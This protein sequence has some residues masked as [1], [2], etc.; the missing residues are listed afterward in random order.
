MKKQ[1]IWSRLFTIGVVCAYLGLILILVLQALT[2]GH[3]SG[4]ISTNVG[5]KIDDTLTQIEKPEAEFIDVSDLSIQGL[6]IDGEL[7]KNDGVLAVGQIGKAVV[8]VQPANASNKSLIYQS[9]DPMIAKAYPDGRLEG[10]KKGTTYLQVTSVSNNTLTAKIPI[11]V[12]DIVLQDLQITHAKES[13]YVGQS[14]TL[15]VKYIPANT[16]Q[17][18]V[19]WTS[20]DPKIVKVN[21]SGKITALA[22]GS[23]VITLQ[24]KDN[25]ALT[26]QIIVTATQKPITP[27]IPLESVT[28]RTET[29]V[30]Y[31]GKSAKLSVS[32]FPA[33]T[34]QKGVSWSVSDASVATVSQSGTLSFLKA[35]NVTVTAQSN[36]NSNL[37]DQVT[38]T[39][40]EVLSSKIVLTMDGLNEEDGQYSM[41]VATSAHVQAE[42]D[43]D[44]TVQTVTFQS[45]N[46]SIVAI[47][48]DGGI[49][50][51]EAGT[52][53]ITVSTSYDGETTSESFVLTVNPLTF[54]DTI[55]NFYY[56]IRKGIGHFGAFFVLGIFAVL[57]YYRLFPKSTKGK[58]LGFVICLVAGFAVAGITEIL[59]LPIFTE[60]RY[61]SFDDVLL[62][63]NG[64]CCSSLVMYFFIFIAHFIS[65]LIQ[66]K[67]GN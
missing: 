9:A 61:C 17:R 54:K 57:S 60:G 25:S 24:A 13:L 51:L 29:T 35:G 64:Y 32:L 30:G 65:L 11:R 38:F 16:T 36:V 59:Q 19:V 10:V 18:E 3:E 33:D 42:L 8:D 58:L 21:A 46:P 48:E 7:F 55:E 39:V 31:V 67:K 56:T 6:R 50:A 15:D 12:D 41:K 53:T 5:D 43:E 4:N 22:E 49:E 44:A 27:E 63:F 20:S 52:V 28:I 2:P 37:F 47:G 23:A 62:D 1:S 40:K 45:S 34:T 14:H 26:D 66:S